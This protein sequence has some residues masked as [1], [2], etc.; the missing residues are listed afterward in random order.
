MSILKGTMAWQ[1]YVMIPSAEKDSEESERMITAD[2]AFHEQRH[3]KDKNPVM[4]VVDVFGRA[5]R[6][7][8]KG[9]YSFHGFDALGIRFDQKTMNATALN[10]LV[11]EEVQK[12]K[13]RD[14]VENLSKHRVAEIKEAV[15]EAAL[16]MQVASVKV[17]D[18]IVVR[19]N[20]LSKQENSRPPHSYLCA[21]NANALD[22]MT[23]IVMHAFGDMYRERLVDMLYGQGMTKEQIMDDAVKAWGSTQTEMFDAQIPP[24]YLQ[25]HHAELLEAFF[26]W[27]WCQI[28]SMDGTFSFMHTDGVKTELWLK[29]HIKLAESEFKIAVSAGDPGFSHEIMHALTQRACRP[30]E[31]TLGCRRNLASGE[32]ETSFTIAITPNHN[33]R[34]SGVK[35]PEMTE[36]D[37]AA[38]YCRVN[39]L[40]W[41]HDM[42]SALFRLFWAEFAS[43]QWKQ[44]S[45]KWFKRELANHEAKKHEKLLKEG[46]ELVEQLIAFNAAESA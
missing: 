1:C 2:L 6:C 3:K 26:L 33:L 42:V 37:E 13:E 34:F 20:I 32:S 16:E 39:D 18:A 24:D 12:V 10:L 5:K 9:N 15:L 28:N 38:L 35:L 44:D 25:G 19:G 27:L 14:K 22:Y 46:A 7:K 41:L 21:T 36:K 40:E 43:G 8:Y 17:Y 23:K 31:L 45:E 29:S 4:G 30:S 11:D